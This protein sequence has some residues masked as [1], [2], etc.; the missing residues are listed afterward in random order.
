MNRKIVIG[1]KVA[2]LMKK[3]GR[4]IE[5]LPQPI[6]LIAVCTGGITLAQELKKYFDKK[7][8]I[9]ET[10]KVWTDTINHKCYLRKTDFKKENYTGSAVIIEDVV[11]RGHH[12]PPIKKMLRKMD[13]KKKFYVAALFD[14]GQLCD[15]SVFP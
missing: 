3:L 15:F 1:N 8:I 10:Y 9:S 4:K 13:S 11:W 14:C 7:G 2:K 12:L 6:H 5:K